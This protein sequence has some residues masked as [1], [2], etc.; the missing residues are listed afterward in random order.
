MNK[1]GGVFSIG[2]KEI[3]YLALAVMII[4]AFILIFSKL[5]AQFFGQG[6]QIQ[7]M[8]KSFNELDKAI[9]KLLDDPA[10]YAYTEVQ[11]QMEDSSVLV[12]YN[13]NHL[14]IWQGKEIE[15]CVASDT[16]YLPDRCLGRAC[17][18][19]YTDDTYDDEDD[20][21]D[22]VLDVKTYAESIIFLGES[23][24]YWLKD[25]DEFGWQNPR[26]YAFQNNRGEEANFPEYQ[27]A[28]DSAI[29]EGFRYSKWRYS[30]FFLFGQCGGNRQLPVPSTFHVEKLKHG[31]DTYIFIIE[32]RPSSESKY[33]TESGIQRR[34]MALKSAYGALDTSKVYDITLELTKKSTVESYSKYLEEWFGRYRHVMDNE[35]MDDAEREK[36]LF[37]LKL[38]NA[39]AYAHL[40]NNGKYVDKDN[41]PVGYET[42]YRESY[43]DAVRVPMDFW[44]YKEWSKKLSH[45]LRV[46]KIEREEFNAKLAFTKDEYLWSAFREFI[47]VY[48]SP[49]FDGNLAEKY[50][51]F[52]HLERFVLSLPR[53]QA[54][55]FILKDKTSESIRPEIKNKGLR[56]RLA[57]LL[58]SNADDFAAQTNVPKT[59]FFKIFESEL[60]NIDDKVLLA[61]SYFFLSEKLL[62]NPDDKKI[63]IDTVLLALDYLKKASD[64]ADDDIKANKISPFVQKVCLPDSDE[65]IVHSVYNP[66]D[67]EKILEICT[68]I[69]INQAELAKQIISQA[70]ALEKKDKFS[71]AASSYIDAAKIL[72]TQQLASKEPLGTAD[73]LYRETLIKSREAIKKEPDVLFYYTK[74]EQGEEFSKP[75]KLLDF[76]SKLKTALPPAESFEGFY[77]YD[78][79]VLA[80]CTTQGMEEHCIN[81]VKNLLFFFPPDAYDWT[82]EPHTTALTQLIK[83]YNATDNKQECIS[84]LSTLPDSLSSFKGCELSE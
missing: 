9:R 82:K 46:G 16:A 66:E 68:E 8:Q 71:D 45:D 61:E 51:Y 81:H 4:L 17:L 64:N 76:E 28:V 54:L 63:P 2:P 77:E 32:V 79:G 52:D 37:L 22:D 5:G 58:A 74:I 73:S 60:N 84:L 1:R 31:R 27:E 38:F 18:A 47:L 29:S 70:E 43:I 26:T 50:N 78:T 24:Y 23:Q 57:N 25:G 49:Y 39:I 40:G 13:F 48:E 3:M 14:G 67:R 10:D 44:Q 53:E 35:Y 11:L 33:D 7:A 56:L 15:N 72:R 34:R 80:H 65:I 19:L 75:D 42:F 36:E 62:E 59:N 30:H 20:K 6:P 21:D 69:G 83:S 41:I 55:E 12:G